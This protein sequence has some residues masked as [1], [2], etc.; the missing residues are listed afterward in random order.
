MDDKLSLEEDGR[1][2]RFGFIVGKIR[3]FEEGGVEEYVFFPE[4]MEGINFTIK[5]LQQITKRMKSLRSSLS[6]AKE[7]K[8]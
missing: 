4:L 2:L 1:V 3:L 6:K 5:E 8:Q 7:G